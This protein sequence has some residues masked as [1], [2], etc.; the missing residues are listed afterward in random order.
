MNTLKLHPNL[1]L[2]NLFGNFPFSSSVRTNNYPREVQDAQVNN[3]F[4]PTWAMMTVSTRPDPGSIKTAFHGLHEEIAIMIDNGVPTKA[5][6]ETHPNIAALFDEDQYNMSGVLSR[7]AA[8][9]VHSIYLKGTYQ[10]LALQ[11]SP[12]IHNRRRLHRFCLNVSC[13]VP[14]EMDGIT[15][16]RNVRSNASVASADVSHNLSRRI[17]SRNSLDMIQSQ[18]AIHAAHKHP[19]FHHMACVPRICCGDTRNAR[20]HGV[21]AGHE[22]HYTL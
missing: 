11:E 17:G 14:C 22:Q 12:L 13:M 16:A 9:I 7:W 4:V 8:S 3:L 15:I 10:S 20:A 19:R 6:I 21:H 2:E 1:N 5:I 18:S